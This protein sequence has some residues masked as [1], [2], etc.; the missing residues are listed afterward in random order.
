MKP[1]QPPP[2]LGMLLS[3][4]FAISGCAQLP[5]DAPQ[6]TPGGETPS[7]TDGATLCD[8]QVQVYDANC[9]SCH[10]G[11]GAASGLDLSAEH[12]FLETVQVASLEAPDLSL[13]APGEL[14][15]S[16]LY[17][18]VAGT[19]QEVGGSGGTMPLGG[20]LDE[21]QLGVLQA[22]IEAGA[23]ESCQTSGEPTPT[24]EAQTPSPTPTAAPEVSGNSL[25]AVQTQV[26]NVY[27]VSCH[28]GAYAQ[29][30]LDLA[31]GSSWN[32]LVAVPSTEATGMALVAAGLP[33][34]SYLHHKLAGTHATVGGSGTQMPQY[35]PALS[36]ELLTLVDAWISEGASESCSQPDGP[37]PTPPLEPTPSPVPTPVPTP[38]PTP[39]G[40][41]F[42]DVQTAIFNASCTNCHAGT[43]PSGNLT[44]AQG[45]S[46]AALVNVAS[47][48]VSTLK[49]VLPGNPSNSYL[50]HKVAGT[51]AQV[52][53]YG[54]QMPQGGAPLSPELQTLLEQWI[55]EGASETCVTPPDPTPTPIPPTPT[56]APTP[57]PEPGTVVQVPLCGVQTQ[58]FN[59]Y[60]T[61][62][63][64]GSGSSAGLDLSSSKSYAALVNKAAS[65][66]SSMNRVTPNDTSK[67]YLYHKLAGTQSSVGGSG[68][69]MPE[70]G[71]YLS[72]QEL[73][74]VADWILQGA[75]AYCEQTSSGEVDTVSLSLA[76][77]DKSKG[78]LRVEGSVSMNSS[79]TYAAG[80]S[81]YNGTVSS[82]GKSCQGTMFGSTTVDSKGDFRYEDRG[83]SGLGA[84]VCVQSDGGGVAQKQI[85]Y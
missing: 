82:D 46:Y 62:C 55:L 11:S 54:S 67:S 17:H 32:S 51:H 15:S 26:F 16:Y 48:E 5:D 50:F 13:I 71:P 12:S 30:G 77:G 41:T 72:T 19:H 31:P 56:P 70:G 44:L 58:I 29:Q 57:T 23:T 59:P 73:Q 18:K 42:C 33:Y 85:T 83:L 68:S 27:C 52:G 45:K 34:Q 79:G 63:H 49:R 1:I 37:T 64:S 3:G 40:T 10:S 84:Y 60:C 14:A 7:Q 39:A 6:D 80:V 22:W 28:S 61:K 9:I 2:W 38:G 35:A 24:P 74:L 75:P 81:A 47:S 78:E 4:L 66:L 69:R 65:E 36:S 25:C 21:E 20:E 8:V 43:Y 76:K 53:G